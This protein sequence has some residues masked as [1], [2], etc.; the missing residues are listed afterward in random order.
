MVQYYAVRLFRRV[1]RQGAD[2]II[3]DVMVHIYNVVQH[4]IF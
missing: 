1:V 2:R 3:F 4:I